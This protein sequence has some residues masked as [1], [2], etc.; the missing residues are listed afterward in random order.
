MTGGTA[1]LLMRLEGPVQGWG[2]SGAHWDYRT[3]MDRPS[4]SGVLG[5]VASALGRDFGDD[6]SDLAALRFGVR[7]DRPGH[8]EYDYRMA[9]GGTFPLDARTSWDNPKVPVDARGRVNYGAPRP[10]KGYAWTETAREGL[11]RPFTFIADAGFLVSLTG[12]SVLLRDVHG[13]L[14]R[15]ARLLSLGRRANPASHPLTPTLLPGDRHTT[16][17]D[18]MPLLDTATT[19]H[20]T[21]TLE[22]P[23]DPH[24]HTTT[25]SYEQPPPAGTRGRGHGPILITTRT[26]T[27]PLASEDAA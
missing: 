27:P 6:S 1:T 13:A 8:I 17:G 7:A 14:L 15:P 9:G 22:T 5:L 23:M 16:W 12:S 25:I 21:W 10:G 26:T 2:E 19:N 20:P 18:H 4:K 3:T 11:R 24:D